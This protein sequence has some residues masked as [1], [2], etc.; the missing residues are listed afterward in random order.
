MPFPTLVKDFPNHRTVKLGF[1]N[2]EAD[3]RPFVEARD[4]HKNSDS[5]IARLQG[6]GLQTGL[7]WSGRSGTGYG[8]FVKA[9]RCQGPSGRM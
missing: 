4:F 8:H 7:L 9:G 2:G 5:V 1:R 3:G 6:L